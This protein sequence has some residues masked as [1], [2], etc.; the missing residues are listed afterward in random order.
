MAKISTYDGASP[1][2]A[3]VD[4]RSSARDFGSET[5]QDL[6]GVGEALNKTALVVNQAQVKRENLWA[7]NTT[8]QAGVFWQDKFAKLQADLEVNPANGA[9]LTTKFREE[10]DA[11]TAEQVKSAPTGRARDTLMTQLNSLGENLNGHA[12][13]MEAKARVDYSTQSYLST[14]DNVNKVA[15][16]PGAY[17]TVDADGNVQSSFDAARAQVK[18]AGQTAAGVIPTNTLRASQNDVQVNF[19]KAE[20]DTAAQSLGSIQTAKL[21]QSGKLGTNLTIPQRYQQVL[22]LQRQGRMENEVK[23]KDA[24]GMLKNL[25]QNLEQGG[26]NSTADIEI[27]LNAYAQAN[28]N[29]LEAT[30]YLEKQKGIGV[31][32]LQLLDIKQGDTSVSDTEAKATLTSAASQIEAGTLPY[33]E[34]QTA[35]ETYAT[36]RMSASENPVIKVQSYTDA[37][38]EG[39]TLLD[40]SLEVATINQQLKTMPIAEGTAYVEKLLT[41]KGANNPV[42]R[43]VV[44]YE[45]QR[46]AMITPGS[47]KFDPVTFTQTDSK[48][49]AATQVSDA[50]FTKAME[51]DEGALLA[52]KTGVDATYALQRQWGASTNALQPISKAKAQTLVN[53]LTSATSSPGQATQVVD[54][55]KKAYGDYAGDVFRSMSNLST[56][57]QRLAMPIQ[58]LAGMSAGLPFR[59]TFAESLARNRDATPPKEEDTKAMAK[60]LDGNGTWQTWQKGLLSTGFSADQVESSKRE[61]QSTILNY[62]QVLNTKKAFG[63]DS[64]DSATNTAVTHVLDS[65]H[66]FGDS[67]GQ[68]M[69]IPRGDGKGGIRSNQEIS[70]IQENLNDARWD[71]FGAGQ[72]NFDGVDIDI[73]GLQARFPHMTPEESRD[74]SIIDARNNSFWSVGNPALAK[75]NQAILMMRNPDTNEKV[76]LFDTKG[77]PILMNLDS[78]TNP[79]IKKPMSDEQ[80]QGRDLIRIAY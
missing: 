60:A 38:K 71:L 76:P 79:P 14:L 33:A 63:V 9:D 53:L 28:G 49:A 17:V 34:G 43:R 7:Q 75:G 21:I 29:V 48:V 46:Q 42:A 68:A 27:A 59:S 19:D 47:G 44:E 77:N 22:E 51:G 40:Q 30:E 13:R 4:V 69:L 74:M 39:K 8:S 3:T 16:G 36:S 80:K 20:I 65:L 23:L 66:G 24:T 50:A 61:M 10:Y 35:L 67:N 26:A 2:F 57:G 12:V 73:R 45:Q 56:D 11:F 64:A 5:A 37:Y 78:L 1:T 70:N 72:S 55:I 54:G 32:N 41:D 25:G 6:Y 18:D 52:V 15:N 31:A 58:V 62:A